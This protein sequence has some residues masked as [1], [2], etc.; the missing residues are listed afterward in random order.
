[1]KKGKYLAVSNEC[2]ISAVGDSKEEAAQRLATLLNTCIEGAV[3][4]RINPFYTSIE[5]FEGCLQYCVNKG[6]K[7]QRLEDI[8]IGNGIFLASYDLS[9]DY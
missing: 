5:R 4:R 2:N 8:E 9:D 3:K 7:P 1:M 6:R